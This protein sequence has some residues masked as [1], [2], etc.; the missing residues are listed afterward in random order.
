MARKQE[1]KVVVSDFRAEETR[2]IRDHGDW[3]RESH[4]GEWIAV[5]GY[6][7][8]AAG[9]DLID[10]ADEAKRQGIEDPLFS[11]VRR[12]R[13]GELLIPGRTRVER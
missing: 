11:I 6:A 3:L 8:V 1:P 9:K 7:L 10:V 13:R 4:P 12:R 2:W 5:E